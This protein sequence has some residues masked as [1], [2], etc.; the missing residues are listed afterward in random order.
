MRA[1]SLL[2]LMLALGCGLVA[3]IGI[4]QVM[5]KRNSAASGEGETSAIFVALED[6]PTGDLIN[7]EVL[8]LED[9]PKDKIPMGALTDMEEVEGRRPK[10]RIYAGSVILDN[11]L[12][13]KGISQGGAGNQIP[14]GYRVVPVKVDEETGGADLIRPSD[15]VDVMVFMQANPTRGIAETCTRT[16]LQDIKVFAVNDVFDLETTEGEESMNAK[17]ISLLVRPNQAETIALANELG[18]IRLVL[19][20]HEDKDEAKLDGAFPHELDTS[21][22]ANRDKEEFPEDRPEG[23]GDLKDFLDWMN[24]QGGEQMAEAT[25]PESDAW[26]VRVIHS[27]AINDVRLETESSAA[28]P[29]GESSGF[30]FWKM[31]M[32]PRSGSPK[33]EEAEPVSDPPEGEEAEAEDEGRQEDAGDENV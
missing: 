20:S 22:M 21:E 27:D 28:A 6:I 23:D 2:L 5:A 8:K 14:P 17:T 31:I 32:P 13:A 25:P 10:S 29:E 1:K 15:R 33:A 11:Q 19:R 12:L 26:T 7:A 9:W 16:I 4:T 30:N 3:S 24:G 18:K